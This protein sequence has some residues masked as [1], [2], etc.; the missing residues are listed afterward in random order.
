MFE[1]NTQGFPKKTV[2][3][4]Y[5]ENMQQ[6]QQNIKVWGLWVNTMQNSAVLFYFKVKC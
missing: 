5:R 4:T 6:M 2:I 3:C 1:M